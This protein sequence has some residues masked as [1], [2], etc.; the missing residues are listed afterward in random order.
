MG[1]DDAMLLSDVAFDGGDAY[2]TALTLTAALRKLG[3]I[4]LVLTGRQAADGDAGVVGA[5]IAEL[6]GIPVV[7]FA[8]AATVDGNTLRVERVLDDGTEIVETALPA[9][10]TV[11]NEIGAPR[12]PSLR[13][14][15]R[16]ARKPVVVWKAPDL[17]LDAAATGSSGAR[18]V[19]ER[20]FAP[21]KAI[22]CRFIDAATPEEQGAQLAARLREAKVL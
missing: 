16:A 4:D 10:V 5:G 15:M 18:S 13:E 21:S 2:T 19:R 3:A 1:A 20:L 7:T 22:Q 9:V 17:G 8:K 12:A 6:L 14:T 11:S